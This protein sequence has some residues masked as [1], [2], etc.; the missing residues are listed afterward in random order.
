MEQDDVAGPRP[1]NHLPS[2][3]TRV[4][5]ACVL[6]GHA[7]A[8]G[9][10]LLFPGLPQEPGSLAAIG[11]PEKGRADA[12]NLFDDGLGLFELHAVAGGRAEGEVAPRV[13]PQLVARLSDASDEVRVLDD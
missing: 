12:D 5:A 6:G 9:D 2:D 3:E 13:V 4:R 11:R 8:Y 1:G 7:P 10:E